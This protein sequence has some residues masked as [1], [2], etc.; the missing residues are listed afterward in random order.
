MTNRQ[1]GGFARGDLARQRAHGPEK[2]VDGLPGFLRE[3]MSGRLYD[4]FYGQ[5]A[6]NFHWSPLFGGPSWHGRMIRGSGD[7]FADKIMR[8]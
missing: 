1:V 3:G 2:A 5:G 7:R 4:L 6:E 8:H